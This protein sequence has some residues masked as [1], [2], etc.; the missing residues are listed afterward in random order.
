[1]LSAPPDTALISLTGLLSLVSCRSRAK[2]ANNPADR[3]ASCTAAMALK[4]G[5]VVVLATTIR[6]VTQRGKALGKP[7]RRGVHQIGERRIDGT[8]LIRWRKA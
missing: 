1:M 7:L 2:P 4:S 3:A 5:V 8:G 6:G